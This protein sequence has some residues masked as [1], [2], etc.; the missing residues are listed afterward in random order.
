[1]GCFGL[2]FH[3]V[4]K[5]ESLTTSFPTR[6]TF[7][8]LVT[9][10]VQIIGVGISNFAGNLHVHRHGQPNLEHILAENF[11]AIANIWVIFP[12]HENKNLCCSHCKRTFVPA[13]FQKR[14]AGS[15]KF[16]RSA[17]PQRVLD[18]LSLI[19]V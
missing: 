9:E 5:L 10:N 7:Y 4:E 8:P 15:H 18:V 3:G 14:L 1:M 16:F 11:F 13:I 19:A 2:T 6:R 12:N 17:F